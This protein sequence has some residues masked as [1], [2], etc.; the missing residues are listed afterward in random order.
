M[1]INN[2]NGFSI[3]EGVILL[4]I[5]LGISLIGYYVYKQNSDTP[6]TPVSSFNQPTTSK[7]AN[8]VATTSPSQ[9]KNWSTINSLDQAYSIKYPKG[10][11]INNCDQNTVLIGPDD[12]SAGKCNSDSPAQVMIIKTEGDKRDT[13]ELKAQDYPDLNNTDVSI[14]GVKGLIQSGTLQTIGETFVGPPSGTKMKQYIFVRDNNTYVFSYIQLPSFSDKQ[15]YFD[16][17][18][19]KTLKFN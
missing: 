12:I 6:A 15:N 14:N 2:E 18:V 1:R 4:I 9:N 17:M 13:L 19:T 10:W 16:Q 5:V 11:V 8:K 7:P 3:I